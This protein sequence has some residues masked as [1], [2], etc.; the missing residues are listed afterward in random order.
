M[1]DLYTNSVGMSDEDYALN[2][3][4]LKKEKEAI[5]DAAK[6]SADEGGEVETTNE[7]FAF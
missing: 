2:E 3:E 1:V 5:L 6:Q 7:D 4:W